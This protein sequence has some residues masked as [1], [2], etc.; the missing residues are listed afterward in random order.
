M[1]SFAHNKVRNRLKHSRA[2]DLVYIYTNSR[3]LRHLKG[4][5][6]ARW[7]GL[8]MVHSDDDLDGDDQDDDDDQ[9]L[10]EDGDDIDNNDIEPMDF[11]IDNLDSDDSHLDGNDGSNR[12]Q[13]FP[14]LLGIRSLSDR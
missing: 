1:Y 13:K 12:F 5:N 6:P 11:D 9:D 10:H 7:Y 14:S 8:N 4:P 3:L 2:E